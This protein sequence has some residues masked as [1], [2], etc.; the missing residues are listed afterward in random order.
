VKEGKARRSWIEDD[1][2]LTKGEHIYVPPHD[3]L[4][5]EVMKESH[6]SK[7]L[8]HQGIHRILALIRDSSYWPH[9]KD[10]VEAYVKTHLVCQQDKIDQG[11]HVEL[12]EI[13][14]IPER[15]WE[16]VFMDFIVG[17]P[18]SER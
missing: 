15:S 13:F 2:I 14:P 6:N 4:R 12:L 16:I 18:T 7:W 5:Q 10:D 11:A 3:N 1:L 9:L 17:L 8:G